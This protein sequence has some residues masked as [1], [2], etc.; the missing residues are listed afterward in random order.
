MTMLA[1]WAVLL[2]RLSGQQDVVIGTPTANRGR[3]EVEGLIGFFVNTLALR[4]DMSSS[5]PVS[6]LLAQVKAQAI[7]AQQHQDI[8]FEQVVEIMR[9]VRSLG[10]SPLFQVMFAWQNASE[11][12]LTLPDLKQSGLQAAPHVVAKFDLSLSLREAGQSIH[13]GLEYATSLF[14]PSTVERHGCRIPLRQVRASTLRGAGSEGPRGYCRGLRGC[15]TYLRRVEPPRQPVGPLPQR[16]GRQARYTR[17]PLRGTRLRDDRRPAGRA[18]GRGRL[19][20]TRPRLPDRS[21]TLHAPG[22]RPRCAAHTKPPPEPL[23]GTQHPAA[24]PRPR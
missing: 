8:P 19:R 15:R 6:E 18:Q 5:P 13:G 3:A 10:H 9:P 4:L 20:P 17:G 11:D 12:R 22:L 21:P 1:A 23:P 16:T 2:A 7:A 24:C 14:E